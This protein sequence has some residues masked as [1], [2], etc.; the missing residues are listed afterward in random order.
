MVAHEVGIV[1]Y[2][3]VP[4]I[5]GGEFLQIHECV[6]SYSAPESDRF[7]MKK[8]LCAV[9]NSNRQVLLDLKDSQA[10]VARHRGPQ[11]IRNFKVLAALQSP[12]FIPADR[13]SLTGDE[14]RQNLQKVLL[15]LKI[16][17]IKITM[18]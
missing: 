13:K 7:S 17:Q 16:S 3:P 4:F 6:L 14:R 12:P 1:K 10:S 5:L 18:G 9:C 2:L 11:E 15:E 8:S